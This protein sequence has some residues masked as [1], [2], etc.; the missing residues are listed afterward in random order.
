MH[1]PRDKARQSVWILRPDDPDQTGDKRC[2]THWK[3]TLM[4]AIQAAREPE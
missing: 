1:Y 4:A 3:P 2:E